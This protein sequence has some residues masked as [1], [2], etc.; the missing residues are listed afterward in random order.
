MYSTDMAKPAGIKGFVLSPIEEHFS[1]PKF[2]VFNQ[3]NNFTLVWIK[4]GLGLLDVD[5]KSFSVRPHTL[6]CVLPGQLHR[7]KLRGEASGYEIHFTKEFMSERIAPLTRALIDSN[8]GEQLKFL[9]CQG[10]L[11]EEVEEIFQEIVLE[12]S[13]DYPSRGDMLHGLLSLVISHFPQDDTVD[14]VIRTVG[15]ERL[16]WIRFISSVQKKFRTQKQVCEYADE[17][18][19]TPN[20]LTEIVRRASGFSPRH[21]IHQR[22][23][24]EA[25]RLAVS[26]SKPAVEIALDLGFD[27]PFTFSKFFKTLTGAT[28]SNFRKSYPLQGRPD[29]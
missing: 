28:F 22:I 9:S 19:V 13:N 24:L 23:L 15:N 8:P 17:L 16:I 12:Y 5:M 21:H 27:N 6:Y 3:H 10:N 7:L 26:S 29:C 20:Y 14:N 4:C 11:A 2:L 18:H 1:Q 25:K